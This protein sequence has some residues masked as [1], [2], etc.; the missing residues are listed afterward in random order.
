MTAR[1]YA[2]AMSLRSKCEVAFDEDP[3]V[4]VGKVIG[5]AEGGESFFFVY[6]M[7]GDSGFR[8]RTLDRANIVAVSQ[9]GVEIH[10]PDENAIGAVLQV[11][12]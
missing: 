9:K 7:R 10:G 6:V 1:A 11:A 5:S 12:L 4:E 3:N 8:S 2:K